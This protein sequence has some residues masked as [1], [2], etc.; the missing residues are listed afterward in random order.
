MPST[1]DST[2]TKSNE[3]SQVRF[4]ALSDNPDSFFHYQD[5]FYQKQKPL[6]IIVKEAFVFQA[7]P[8]LRT[9]APNY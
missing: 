5:F 4:D 1:A 3:L 8:E 2:F 7:Y 9:T 6:Y